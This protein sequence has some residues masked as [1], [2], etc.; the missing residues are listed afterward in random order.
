MEMPYCS[1]S[2]IAPFQDILGESSALATIKLQKINSNAI[3]T[4]FYIVPD[5][6]PKMHMACWQVDF[7]FF[8]KKPS[9]SLII[10]VTCL[11]YAAQYIYVKKLA[12][13]T[14]IAIGS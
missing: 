4:R 11:Y 8:I 6:Y 9:A 5:L 2:E 3:S 12:P 10:Y 14:T 13:L 7:V 1:S